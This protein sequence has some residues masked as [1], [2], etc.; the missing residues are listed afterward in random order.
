LTSTGL[1]IGA[2]LTGPLVPWLTATFGWRYAFLVTAPLAFVLAALWWWYS[3]DR[4]RD[5]WAANAAE[6]ALIEA[7]RP[8]AVP[9]V[10][11]GT[12][13]R[14][15]LRNRD[16]L[17]LAGSYFCMNY[18]FYLFFNWFYYYLTHARHFGEQQSGYF[19]SAQ[20][21]TG[22]VTAT[23]GGLL[24]DWLCRRHGLRWGC[25]L[26][27]MVGLF[28][29]GPLLIGGAL[30][31]DPYVVVALL[32]LS[33]G[34]TQLTEGAY[35]AAAIAIAD[36]HASA[37]C[38]VMNTGGNIVGGIGALLVPATAAAFGWTAAVMTGALFGL[39]GMLLWLGIRADR[40]L[41]KPAA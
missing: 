31:T 8:A 29:M 39:I 16:I 1:T 36:R 10:P 24:C 3:R 17:L 19:I 23:A 20:W 7:D 34:C 37:A 21:I 38:G 27:A 5:H 14:Q 26:P 25:R 9:D 40:P 4:P 32:S 28:L 30:A 11:I 33:F 18:V 12:V 22:A 15:V 2:A 6:I 41:L 35:W 13:L